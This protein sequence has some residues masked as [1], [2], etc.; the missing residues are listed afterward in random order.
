M[1]YK[2]SIRKTLKQLGFFAPI[3]VYFCLFL[4]GSFICLAWLKE[5]PKLPGT[6]F[7]D[8]FSI[9]IRITLYISCTF[10]IIGFISV[11]LS[12]L[13]FLFKRHI[14]Q[15]SFHIT[16]KEFDTPYQPIELALKPILRPILGYIKLRF[17]YDN[18]SFSKKIQLVEDEHANWFNRNLNGFYDWEITDVKEFRISRVVVYFEDF[19]QFFSLTISL[20][21]AERF[22]TPPQSQPLQNLEAKQKNTEI[23]NSRIDEIRKVEGD[24]FSYKKFESHDDLRRIVWKIYAKNKELVIRTPEILE[25]YTSHLYLYVSFFSQFLNNHTEVINN[26]MLNF[27]KNKVWSIYKNLV[28]QNN[29]VRWASDQPEKSI[30]FS[31]NPSKEE[32]IKHLIAVSEWQNNIDMLNFVQPQKA[33]ILVISSLTNVKQ[34]KQ[35]IEWHKNE[36]N[37]LF[38]PISKQFKRQGIRS[39]ITWFFLEQEKNKKAKNRMAWTFFPLRREI[40]RNEKE[41]R[42]ILKSV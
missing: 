34:V 3:T 38:V 24:L 27:Y 21:T 29:D 6:P 15:I 5:Q 10:L 4:V 11:L 36:I 19:L 32:E 41:L 17:I 42:K 23:K 16:T 25:P 9:L 22:Y 26:A 31:V 8:I 30:S 7:Q 13:F 40:L 12:W 35:L 39:W 2:V 37:F 18:G 1:Q 33:A 14:K 28:H 20:P